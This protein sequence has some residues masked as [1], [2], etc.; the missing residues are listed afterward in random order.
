MVRFLWLILICLLIIVCVETVYYYNLSHQE[1]T[2]SQFKIIQQ[3][4]TDTEGR[5]VIYQSNL[6]H[7][8]SGYKGENYVVAFFD[9]FEPVPNSN[10]SYIVLKRGDKKETI[11]YRLLSQRTEIKSWYVMT[12]LGW[13]S[14]DLIKQGQVDNASGPLGTYSQLKTKI[15]LL[16][17]KNDV[18][19]VL[20]NT[21]PPKEEVLKDE[22]QVPVALWLIVRRNTGKQQINL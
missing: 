16:F 21:P 14:L 4:T 11:K 18:V 20:S 7:S 3:N 10:D 15:N 19:I 1:N 9:H 8:F 12:K 6:A 2:F 5:T 22:N 17:K 13:E